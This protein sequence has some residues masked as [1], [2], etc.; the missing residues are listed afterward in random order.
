VWNSGGERSDAHPAF[1]KRPGADTSPGLRTNSA[2]SSLL[3]VG[4]LMG[5]VQT[6]FKRFS[7]G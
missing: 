5:R 3:T 6:R 2:S 4:K 7:E 1:A